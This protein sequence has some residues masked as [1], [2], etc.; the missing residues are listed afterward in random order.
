MRIAQAARGLNKGGE[1]ETG[2][3]LPSLQHHFCRIAAD[4][5]AGRLHAIRVR[6]VEPARLQ[7]DPIHFRDMGE[8]VFVRRVLPWRKSLVV[9]RVITNRRDRGDARMAMGRP[10]QPQVC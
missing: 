2:I 6:I 8:Q 5:H 4:V 7:A 3:S 9:I 10:R 1:R